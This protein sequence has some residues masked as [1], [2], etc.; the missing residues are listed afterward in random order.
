MGLKKSIRSAAAVGIWTYVTLKTA[1]RGTVIRAKIR[2]RRIYLRARTT[3]L[4]VAIDSLFDEYEPLAGLLPADFDGL[5][6]DAGAYIGT[7]SIRLT[8]LYPKA[9]I[10]AIEPS[11]RNFQLLEQ[12]CKSHPQI[13]PQKFALSVRVSSTVHLFDPGQREWGFTIVPSNI[14]VSSR[15]PMEVVETTTLEQIS[16]SYAKPIGI[17]K[18]DIEGA[19][20]ELFR[21]S[22]AVLQAVP[23]IFVE[24]HDRD[25]PGCYESFSAFSKD[26]KVSK[27]TG[28]KY[29]SLLRY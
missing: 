18:L 4:S 3:D 15:K 6:V 5:I 2:G 20:V 26:R 21:Q 16:K 19:E 27:G 25:V 9:T 22:D 1:P 23:V 8:E 12:N 29:L 17:L 7:A 24:L 14:P 13:H 10:V 28:E 11:S